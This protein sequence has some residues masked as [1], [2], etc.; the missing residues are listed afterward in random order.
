MGPCKSTGA[1]SVPPWK[2][3]PP[4]RR[5]SVLVLGLGLALLAGCLHA[6]VLWSP[7]G[8]WIAY[9]IAVRPSAPVVAPGWLYDVNTGADSK[10]ASRPTLT[11]EAA[12]VYRLWA[13]RV[14]SGDSV[15][16]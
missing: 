3:F 10:L 8:R 12:G 13:T 15:L 14:D 6:P 9:T 11:G 7:D 4:M 2:G 16:L 1:P 5:S